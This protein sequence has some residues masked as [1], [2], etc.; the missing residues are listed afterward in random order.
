MCAHKFWE[1]MQIFTEI[2]GAKS[3]CNNFVKCEIGGFYY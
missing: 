1:I 2:T 3:H